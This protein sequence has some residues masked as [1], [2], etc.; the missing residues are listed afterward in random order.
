M[1]VVLAVC[2]ALA[3]GGVVALAY[4]LST[5]PPTRS[6]GFSTGVGKV[7]KKTW[8]LVVLGVGLGIVA[9]ALTGWLVLLLAVPVLVVGVASLLGD[10]A[11]PELAMLEALDR[12]VRT[13]AATLP[14]GQSVVEALRVSRRQAPPLLAR[15]LDLAVRR[16]DERWTSREALLALADDLASPDA[17]AVIAA[18]VLA[19]ERGGTG[20]TATL[21]GLADSLGERL[22][23]AREIEAEQAKPRIVVRQVTVITL[24]VLTLAL[25]MGRGFFAPYGTP[26]GQVVLACLLAAYLGSLLMM[27]RLTRPRRRE[28][29][30]GRAA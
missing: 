13:M 7:D 11:N 25:V 21:A 3:L 8:R 14:T 26:M 9:F 20:A 22:R 23:A 30:L 24:V 27:R 15:P 16:L 29:I 5:A 6:T 19:A 28:R 1:I 17:D 2:G 18:L 12:W 10:P 4:G